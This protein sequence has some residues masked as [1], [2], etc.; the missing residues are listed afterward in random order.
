M[1]LRIN[2]VS[3]T[4]GAIGLVFFSPFAGALDYSLYA[5]LRVQA[6][7]VDPNGSTVDDYT[8]FRDAYSRIGITAN[9]DLAENFSIYGKLELPVDVANAQ[10]QDPFDQSEEIRVAKI[11]AKGSFGDLSYGQMW[12]PYYNAIAYPVDMFS[13]YYS[14]FATFTSFRKDGTVAYY[15]PSLA[16]FSAAASYSSEAGAAKA[17]G[18]SDSRTQATITY[19]NEGLTLAGGLDDLGGNNDLKIWGASVMWQATDALYIGAKY[20]EHDS[21]ISGGYGADGDSAANL[22]AGYTL[23]KN[24]FKGM[25]AEVD[26]YGETVFHLGVDH[27]YN[28]DLKFFVEY[29]RE[30]DAAAIVKRRDGGFC[31]A[32]EGGD[33]LM[34]GLRYD[35]ATP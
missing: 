4:A 32:C 33:A 2:R 25:V 14:G 8:G 16:G 26:N 9:H 18:R 1:Q 3:V 22:Y 34:V 7:A 20:E 23:G 30:Q 35:F 19:T 28:D 10:I 31:G 21:D 11:G 12:L 6:E 29:Y 24:T 13:S 27:Q 17:S 5:S 15:T